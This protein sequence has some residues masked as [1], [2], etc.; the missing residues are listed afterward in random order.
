M[1]AQTLIPM[2]LCVCAT[3]TVAQEYPQFVQSMKSTKAA[4]DVLAKAEKRTGQQTVRAAERLSGIYEEMIPFWRARKAA[5]AVKISEEG[6]AAA[7]EL[8]NAANADDADRANDAFKKFSGTC[9][10]CHDAHR[11][12]LDDGKYRIK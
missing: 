11:E 12:K 2:M 5:D 4:M 10:S 1:K 8:A 3:A 6:K 7:I 9:K